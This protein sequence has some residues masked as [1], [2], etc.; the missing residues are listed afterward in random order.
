MKIAR[1]IL[2]VLLLASIAF[3]IKEQP[4]AASQPPVAQASPSTTHR[5]A[6]SMQAKLDHIQQNGQLS[7]PDQTPTVM[8][9]EEVNDYIASGHIVMPQGVKK[10]SMEGRSGVVTA[11]L[12]VDFDEIRAGQN[13]ANPLLSVF[14]GRH[15]VR[16]EADAAG[17]G[18][19]GRV[20]VRDVSIDGFAVPHMALEYFVSKYITP[21]YPNV[22]LD[23][24]FRLPDKVDLATVG[25]HKLTVTQK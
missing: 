16:V 12:N 21:K 7:T 10:L 15:D 8:S 2:T 4:W 9:E 17:S 6:Q 1:A 23:S 13:S 19:Q 5:L 24:Q 22:G 18:G 14:N 20:H 11:F 25:Y 3:I